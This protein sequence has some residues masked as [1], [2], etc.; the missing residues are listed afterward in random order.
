MEK[1]TVKVPK[2]RNVLAFAVRD[3]KGAFRPKTERD[4]SKYSR[5]VKHNKQEQ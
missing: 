1:I 2:P 5:K 3:P 4:R